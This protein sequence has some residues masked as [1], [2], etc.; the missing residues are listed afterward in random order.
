MRVNICIGVVVSYIQ[1]NALF[2]GSLLMFYLLYIKSWRWSHGGSW[3]RYLSCH[4]LILKTTVNVTVK[5]CFEFANHA[6]LSDSS[7]LLPTYAEADHT[8]FHS[9]PTT[10]KTVYIWR[11]KVFPG[12]EWIWSRCTTLFVLGGIKHDSNWQRRRHISDSRKRGNTIHI[13]K[14]AISNQSMCC[15]CLAW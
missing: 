8:A 5:V 13:K 10:K 6:K 3:I 4:S 1:R 9:S 2:S 14:L 11:T 15:H 7:H 12:R